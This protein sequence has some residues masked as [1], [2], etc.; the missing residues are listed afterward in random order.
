M[1]KRT[2]HWCP[3]CKAI[4]NC[5]AESAPLSRG[6]GP[7]KRID[8]PPGGD[9][10]IDPRG[11]YRKRRC[12][13]CDG[14]WFTIEIPASYVEELLQWRSETFEGLSQMV[15]RLEDQI[16]EWKSSYDTTS[17]DKFEELLAELEA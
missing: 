14:D 7:S 2:A 17:D 6:D 15:K 3:Y 10:Q 13:E 5:T 1:A 11:F 12:N 8:V 16:Q 4:R 9:R